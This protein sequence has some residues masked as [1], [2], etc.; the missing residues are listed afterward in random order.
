MA[1]I[2]VPKGLYERLRKAA[3]LKEHDEGTSTRFLPVYPF[4]GL[5]RAPIG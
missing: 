2:S 3:I 1:S 5:R 4:K